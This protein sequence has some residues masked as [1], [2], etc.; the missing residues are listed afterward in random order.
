MIYC[1][2]NLNEDRVDEAFENI[3]KLDPKFKEYYLLEWSKYDIKKYI[4]D[5]KL[6]QI[7]RGVKQFKNV[8]L[9]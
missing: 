4:K 9:G 7:L 3:Y 2:I 6:G 8:N 5:F 1:D